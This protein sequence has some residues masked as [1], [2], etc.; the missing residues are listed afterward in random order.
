M[1]LGT[2]DFN[3]TVCVSSSGKYQTAI[4]LAPSTDLTGN[5]N[6]W[7]SS[8]FGI[9]WTDTENRTPPISGNVSIMTSISMT[10]LGQNQLI[11]YITGNSI[12]GRYNNDIVNILVS[13]NYGVSWV[14]TNFKAPSESA[15]GNVYVGGVTKVQSSLNGQY[16][17]GISKY[18]D[19]IG[20][21]YTNNTNSAFG[22]GNVF[23]SSIPITNGIFSTQYF[24]SDN[25]GNV[26]QTHGLQLSVPTV[27]TSAIVAGYDVNWD[28]A[29]INSVD[30]NGV[31][32]LCLNTTGGSVGIG[33][34]TPAYTLDVV[35]TIRATG[36][37][38]GVSFNATSDYR[39][40]QNAQ[41]LLITRSIDLLKPV[42][43]DLSGGEHDMGFL[44]HEVQEVLPFLI[45]GEKDGPGM[46]S[47]NY[48][49]FI[50]LIVKEVQDLKKEN[51][52]LKER[53][54]RLEKYFM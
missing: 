4:G 33:T 51:R 52:E 12:N 43:Y 23:L 20:N 24:G 5:A 1:N 48:N 37:I 10:G 2:S 40:K 7:I 42:E 29:Y 8:D 25:T 16:V 27:N 44:A 38:T 54:N 34:V 28:I 31:N 15:F 46:Q 36:Q 32:P 17:I 3:K 6:I 19:I 9:T 18:Q 13:N 22:V 53:M 21:T 47:M 30:Q 39:M 41:P 11:T 50:A 45:T 26:F 14:D 49:G 35:G